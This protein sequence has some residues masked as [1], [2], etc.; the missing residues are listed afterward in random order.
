VIEPG[1]AFGGLEKFPDRP[2]RGSD[3]GKLPGGAAAKGVPA[4]GA[5]EIVGCGHT[6]A[7]EEIAI[8]YPEA[9]R[10]G[11]AFTTEGGEDPSPRKESRPMSSRSRRRV[12]D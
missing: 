3:S 1:L 8:I 2:A 9:N 11:A 6:L 5:T 7:G 10:T 4:R 12:S